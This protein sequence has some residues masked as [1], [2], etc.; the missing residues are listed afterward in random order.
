MIG[1]DE[2]GNA[3]TVQP[4]ASALAGYQLTFNNGHE[5]VDITVGNSAD[6]YL[7][8]GQYYI[9][10]TA[11]KAGGQIG[12]DGDA[13]ASGFISLT[14]SDGS[15]DGGVV[16]PIILGPT[17]TGNG[18]LEYTITGA[19]AVSGTMKLWQIN[20]TSP[21]S[22]FGT[23]GVLSI[24][25][26]PALSA[27]TYS[28]A[29][30]RYITEIRLVDG[31]GDIALMRE[32]VEIW[33]G[34]TTAVVFE[35]SGYLDPSAVPA[36]SGAVL[37]AISTI[38]GV[39]I[40]A[41]TGTGVD[42][43]NAVT[44]VLSVPNRANAAPDLVLESASR[45]ADISWIQNTG[46][47]PG[48]TGY[49][50]WG[51]YNFTVNYVLWVKVVS[52]DA[53]T[54]RFYKFKVYPLP[55][56]D[57]SFGDTDT[58]SGR[59]GGNITWTA[60]AGTA[61]ISG[62]RIYFGA[63]PD[64][65][66][67]SWETQFFSVFN[68][69]EGSYTV[70]SMQLPLGA[71]YFLVYYYLSDDGGE[72]PLHQSIP[73]L[74]ATFS[75]A[76][77]GLEVRGIEGSGGTGVSWSDPVL[78]IS[79]GSYYISGSSGSA[80]IQVT[81]NASITLGNVSIDVSGISGAAAFA[82][83]PGVAVNL[84]LAG[85]N[86]LKSG[87]NKAGLGVPDTA[88]LTVTANS[89]GSLE[90]AGGGTGAGIGGNDNEAGGTVIINGGTVTA[91]GG[92]SGAGIG[93][94]YSGAGGTVTISGGT[95]TATGRSNA[96]GIG[97][98]NGGAGG[99]I[100]IS[101]GTVTATGGD[102]G[103]GI[104][105]GYSGTGGT[106]TISGGTVTATGGY[107][108]YGGGAGIGGG[109]HGAGGTV[110]I[111]GGMVT[112]TG[113]SD[114]AGIGGSRY[115]S[116]AGA[117]TELSGNAVIFASSIGPT[118]TAGSNATQAIVF[119]GVVGTMY[120]H[121]TLQQDLTI[122]SG[123]ILYI[124]SA[125]TLTIPPARTLTN[126]GAI[127]VY[128]G[129]VITGNVSGNQPVDPDLTV[130][131]GS[132]YTAA[133]GVLTI[134]GDGSYTIGMRRGVSVTTLERIVVTSGVTADITL[135][136]VHIDISNSGEP[137]F[138]MTGATVNLTLTGTNILK[139]GRDRAGLEAPSGSTLTITGS[140][141]G[142][143]DA[144]GGSYYGAGIGGGYYGAGGTVT[145]SGGTVTATGGS[146]AAGIGGGYYGAGGT[147]TISGGMVTA[148][149]GSDAAGIGA[150]RYNNTD[151]T[152][153]ELSGNAVVFASSI[154]STLT[155]GSNATQAIA[156]N[157]TAGTMYG[158]VTLQQDITI[159]SDNTLDFLSGSQTLTIP[160]TVTLTN[161]GT[162]NK[163]GGTIDDTAGTLVNNGTINN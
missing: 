139:S 61:G 118:L 152:I 42:E 98:G 107:G 131:G 68:P 86:T 83:D 117:I 82:I 151:G 37:S 22:G 57:G 4:A 91:T 122:P 55:P 7:A 95:V 137:A 124:P 46:A 100:T 143:L 150:G 159:P 28:L 127:C 36:N 29:A 38:G 108:R 50:G 111:S 62:Y 56:A 154:G 13:V 125:G 73:I 51:V 10:A 33:P 18:T 20:G 109:S 157:G 41:G 101:G 146:D 48:N 1:E 102:D 158:D 160:G 94:S 39:A 69:A 31:N 161:D 58:Q 121:V 11:Y 5:P 49:S 79:G 103:A 12:N 156:F 59:I 148:T 142:S 87:G 114:A 112:A 54:T 64:I 138:D 147:V 23:S 90:A 105:G 47:V 129:G 76:Y 27:E 2:G 67:P 70:S 163:N 133:G 126:E 80:R 85:V 32:V 6:V 14:L 145:I 25:A 3:R 162:I 74:D 123:R 134:A 34:I 140:S 72:Y 128:T 43:A 97:G 93:G 15:V 135:N 115:S 136:G 110:T 24:G 16:P 8:D 30:G 19:A 155:A 141:T 52:E 106:V 96:A 116:N 40:G 9:T 81:G 60:P 26:A 77:G 66:L 63:T 120:G 104:G 119:N 71:D 89:V 113:G 45:F 65:K 149:G 21:V 44:Y 99:T 153:T 132:S 84:R 53:T 144:T 130:T 17:G 88:S 75:A 92:S 78:S 35:P